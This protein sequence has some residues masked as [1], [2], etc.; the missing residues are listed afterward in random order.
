MATPRPPR[1]FRKGSPGRQHREPGSAVSSHPPFT[2]A[3]TGDGEHEN[4]DEHDLHGVVVSAAQTA[5]TAEGAPVMRSRSPDGPAW[6]SSVPSGA[7]T[8]RPAPISTGAPPT[9]RR[10]NTP[11]SVSVAE[12]KSPG[13]ASMSVIS[14]VCV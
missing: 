11:V 7:K 2:A 4:G 8:K 12:L 9:G 6:N 3:G 13:T 10:L 1:L 14:C 5:A